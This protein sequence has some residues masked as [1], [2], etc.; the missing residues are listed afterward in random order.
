MQGEGESV[1]L[2]L[3]LSYAPRQEFKRTRL[4]MDYFDQGHL[5]SP[6]FTS[7]IT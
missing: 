1:L 5:L 3:V 7:W 6:T 4:L 2:L